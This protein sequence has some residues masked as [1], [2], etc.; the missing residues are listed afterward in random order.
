MESR[1]SSG[2]HRRAQYEVGFHAGLP[3]SP[4]SPPQEGCEETVVVQGDLSPRHSLLGGPYLVRQSPGASSGGRPS[5]SLPRR[6]RLRPVDRGASS[7]PGAALPSRLEDLRGSWGVDAVSDRSFRLI[8]AGWKRSSEDC[9][10]RACQ[11][12]KTFLRASSI[13]LCQATLKTV[14]DYLTHLYDRGLS[15]SSMGIHRSTISMTNAPID[16][17]NIGDHPLVKRL[18]SGI[19]NERPSRQANPAFFNTGL[20][21]SP[22]PAL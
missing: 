7:I 5:S 21:V 10:E 12:F 14:L 8:A 22:F 13:P 11:S 1:G 2:S 16:G 4:H 6:P 18:M 19:F 3:F 20:S 15:W 17:A 9:Y